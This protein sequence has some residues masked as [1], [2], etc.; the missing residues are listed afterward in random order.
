M[1]GPELVERIIAYRDDLRFGRGT[2]T[3]EAMDLMADAANA[4]VSYE[5][6]MRVIAEQTD[7]A[8]VAIGRARKAL[9]AWDRY[10]PHLTSEGITR[11]AND[12]ANAI[13]E[14]LSTSGVIPTPAGTGSDD[15]HATLGDDANGMN[16]ND[17]PT[18]NT[19]ERRP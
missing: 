4:L 16:N 14:I 2:I 11:Q 17:F 8:S 1:N 13:R 9:A 3:R 19:E 6:T 18:P 10:E 5:K 12:M 7:T 15:S